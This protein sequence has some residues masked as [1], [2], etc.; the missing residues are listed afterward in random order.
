MPRR[1]ATSD[2]IDRFEV[3]NIG[4]Y[5]TELAEEADIDLPTEFEDRDEVQVNAWV[6]NG[7]ILRLV[8]NPF[9]PTRIPYSA[10]P[11]ELNP[12]SLFGIGVAEN[13]GYAAPMNDL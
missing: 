2:A 8:I 10:V 5:W 12:Y 3:S 1:C 6:C 7:Q 4:E 9:T 13:M 11:Y